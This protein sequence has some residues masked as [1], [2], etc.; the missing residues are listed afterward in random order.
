MRLRRRAR[1][2]LRVAAL[3]ALAAVL[4]PPLHH[5]A[6]TSFAAHMAQHEL[7]MLVAAPLVA[8]GWPV[9]PWLAALPR[10]VRRRAL[11]MP[12]GRRA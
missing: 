10:P 6:E 1:L 11:R 3:A 9:A 2:L 7:L 4:G 8:L 12:A 5:A